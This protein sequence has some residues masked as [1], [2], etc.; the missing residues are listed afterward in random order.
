MGI[1]WYDEMRNRISRI[2]TQPSWEAMNNLALFRFRDPTKM[3]KLHKALHAQKKRNALLAAKLRK[4]KGKGKK[5]REVRPFE[6]IF[7]VDPSHSTAIDMPSRE[8]SILATSM[9][10]LS[11]VS[12]NIPDCK[13]KEK[14]EDI[15]RKSFENWRGSIGGIDGTGGHIGRTHEDQRV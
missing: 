15:D 12:I 4:I 8:N 14:G 3:G 11:A 6:E 13:P 9:N 7:D 2:W 1:T 5:I 10:A